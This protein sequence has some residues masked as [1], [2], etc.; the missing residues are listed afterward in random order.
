MAKDNMRRRWRTKL[1]V[2]YEA[3]PPA[4]NHADNDA[5]APLDEGPADAEEDVPPNEDTTTA[6]HED[7]VVTVQVGGPVAALDPEGPPE[8]TPGAA[9]ARAR[10]PPAAEEDGDPTTKTAAGEAPGEV[11][12]TAEG[13]LTTTY[14]V[15]L[16]NG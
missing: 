7:P 16:M 11:S 5:E 12:A 13:E 9:R 10:E 8:E 6:G 15:V 3:E 14:W 4:R 2:G 1:I